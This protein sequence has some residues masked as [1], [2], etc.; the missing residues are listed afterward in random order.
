[1]L[2]ADKAKSQSLRKPRYIPSLDCTQAQHCPEGEC[3]K[4]QSARQ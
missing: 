2:E 3:N 4:N 1:M